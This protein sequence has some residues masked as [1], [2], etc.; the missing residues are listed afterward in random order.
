MLLER[1]KRRVSVSLSQL[2]Q[3]GFLYSRRD[4][5]DRREKRFRVLDPEDVVFAY[6]IQNHVKGKGLIARLKAASKFLPFVIGG[7]YA[8]YNFHR[9][10]TPGGIDL[11]IEEKDSDRWFAFLADRQISLSLDKDLSEKRKRENVH[12]HTDLSAEAMPDVVTIDGLR[13]LSPEELVS[14]GLVDQSEFAM[15][16][17]IAILVQRR[18]LI[19]WSNLLK[20][21]EDERFLREL[22]CLLEIVNFEAGSRVFSA[23]IIS[24][25][26]NRVGKS[27]PRTFPKDS[28]ETS[29]YAKVGRKWNLRIGLSR[30]LVS[31]L[32]QDL[33]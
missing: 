27:V 19:H 29:D 23:K 17:T 3:R 26:R 32:V 1:E 18:N 9:Y 16:D 7:S 30:A 12:L 10:M 8:A 31:K 25:V 24:K 4:P 5:V 33:I 28:K 21:A 2:E 15:M 20:R 14:R 22:G 13:Y 11:H 6:A